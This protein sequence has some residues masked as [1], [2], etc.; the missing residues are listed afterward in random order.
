MPIDVS[1]LRPQPL[2]QA[3]SLLDS[4][5]RANQLIASQSQMAM[6]A[7]QLQKAQRES[8]QEYATNA[9]LG[10][11]GM[12]NPETGEIDYGALMQAA[13]GYG[14][15]GK[16]PQFA[17]M[18]LEQRKASREA[19]EAKFKAAQE[20]DKAASARMAEIRKLYS[21]VNSREGALALHD[22]THRDP[23]MGPWLKK[24]GINPEDGAA[25]IR[26][27][28]D[29]E[30]PSYLSRSSQSLDDVIKQTADSVAINDAWREAGR[31]SAPT[32]DTPMGEGRQ[33][34]TDT[35]SLYQN[36]VD[37]LQTK[38]RLDLADKWLKQ[39]TELAMLPYAGLPPAAAELEALRRHPELRI[40]KERLA[41]LSA[42]KQIFNLGDKVQAK[43]GE[44]L[45]GKVSED[46]INKM[47]AAEKAP[48]LSKTADRILA[49]VQDPQLI[50]GFGAEFRLNAA[51]ALNIV[52][53][54]D[55]ETVR[56]TELLVST[57]GSQTLNA[58]QESG[59]GTG[60]GF[61]DK[62]RIFL[63]EAKAG[64]IEFSRDTLARMARL[65]RKAAEKSAERWNE[66]RKRMPT[67]VRDSM[68]LPEEVIIK[69]FDP[70]AAKIDEELLGGPPEQL[71]PNQVRLKSGRI[72][73]FPNKKSADEFR[74]QNP[75]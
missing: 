56:N 59:L 7:L 3:P 48:D 71:A 13:P 61:T 35:L 24:R 29:E 1:I 28:K 32:T 65:A 41:E 60:Q 46:D 54:S 16:V 47:K 49:L 9:L 69:P 12:I 58:I 10:Q 2:P 52:G 25:Q 64:R 37:N 38:G 45:A 8:E 27:L 17:K 6:N 50:T 73:T 63:Q 11:P 40:V 15:G 57:L 53:L 22:M 4:Q 23:I 67:E 14:L 39:N 72:A 66:R 36:F 20:E 18:Q 75:E 55:D 21:Q 68:G 44:A 42:P 30:V 43:Y 62:D 31:A 19:E 70:K 33:V 34:S 5:A 26:A 51:R 74:R